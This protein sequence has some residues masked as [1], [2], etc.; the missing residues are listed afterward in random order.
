MILAMGVIVKMQ[1]YHLLKSE[2]L[3]EKKSKIEYL[4]NKVCSDILIW[5][6]FESAGLVNLINHCIKARL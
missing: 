3:S 2:T 1:K 6:T 4:N 5:Y